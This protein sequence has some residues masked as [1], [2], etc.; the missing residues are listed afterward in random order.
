MAKKIRIVL[1][2]LA[3]GLTYAT[4]CYAGTFNNPISPG[5]VTAEGPARL[6]P[7]SKLPTPQL[8][9]S[10]DGQQP[11]TP[12]SDPVRSRDF[13]GVEATLAGYRQAFESMSLQQVTAVWPTVDKRRTKAFKRTFAFL[14][15]SGAPPQLDLACATPSQAG[16]SVVVEC[17]QTLTYR[18]EKN[19]SETLGPVRVAIS[20]SKQSD[21]WFIHG[22]RGR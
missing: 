5:T 11:I 8:L 6:A 3:I 19:R 4:F 18:G 10:V 7:E 14:K 1:W 21:T 9:A 12:M 15:K 17:R 13:A 20:L 22:M 2:L 16:P